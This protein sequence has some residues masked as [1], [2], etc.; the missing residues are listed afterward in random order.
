MSRKMS[1]NFNKAKDDIVKILAHSIYQ[2]LFKDR[3]VDEIE[4]S[5]SG[6]IDAVLSLYGEKADG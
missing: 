4:E 2:G 5:V 1:E 6:N 3:S